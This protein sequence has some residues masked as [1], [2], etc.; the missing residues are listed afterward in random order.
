MIPWSTGAGEPAHHVL[1][2]RPVLAR[3]HEAVV[4]VHLAVLPGEPL[5]ALALI[6]GHTVH[7]EGPVGA[8]VGAA[9]V[10]VLLAPDHREYSTCVLSLRGHCTT[11]RVLQSECT[12]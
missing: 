9:L 10:N 2:G 5:K 11:S 12:L 4:V 1:A 6:P 8:W 7:A 3:L